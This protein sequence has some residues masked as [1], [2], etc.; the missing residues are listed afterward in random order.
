MKYIKVKDMSRSSKSIANQD[1][2]VVFSHKLFSTLF[3]TMLLLFLMESIWPHSVSIYFDVRYIVIPAIISG[4]ADLLL[5]K[6]GVRDQKRNKQSSNI[7]HIIL[8]IVIAIVGLFAVEYKLSHA[9]S[10]VNEVAILLG[11]L[12]LTVSLIFCDFELNGLS[13]NNKTGK[14]QKKNLEN[15]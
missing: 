9:T 2:L 15:K 11:M 5:F 13:G 4:L 12:L 7:I 14:Q 3:I 6:E 8:A 1:K 10:I